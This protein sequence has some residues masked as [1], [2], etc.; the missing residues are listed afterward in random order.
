MISLVATTALGARF[1]RLEEEEVEEEEEG[2][3]RS[4]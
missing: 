4:E 2:E 3:K 1:L